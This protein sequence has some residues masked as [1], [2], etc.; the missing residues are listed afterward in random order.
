MI[1]KIIIFIVIALVAVGGWFTLRLMDTKT[2]SS[3]PTSE[4]TTE[5]DSIT[6][7]A[8]TASEISS[9]NS[10]ESCWTIINGDV[11]DLTKFISMH[12][13]GDEILKA[14]GVDATDYFT[15]KH[16]TIGRVHSQLAVKLL[17][18]MKI[19]DLQQ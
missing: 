10:K 2:S 12:K 17:Q 7:T 11:F 13:G 6:E 14:C 3:T 19:G 15:G 5:R 18:G 16:P 9:H 4:K 1:K 8:F